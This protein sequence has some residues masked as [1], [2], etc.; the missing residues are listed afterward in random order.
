[1]FRA[2]ILLEIVNVALGPIRRYGRL[3]GRCIPLSS[4]VFTGE[5]LRDSV[6]VVKD[7]GLNGDVVVQF[8]YCIPR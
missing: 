4:L 7:I 8:R 1:M 3:E 5:I 2:E 6:D